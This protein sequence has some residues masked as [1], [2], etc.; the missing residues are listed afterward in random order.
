MHWTAFL[1]YHRYPAHA[2]VIADLPCAGC[3]YNLRSML[4]N[5]VCPE[6]GALVRDSLKVLSD[7]A[8]VSHSLRV[9]GQ[10]HFAFIFLFMGCIGTAAWTG[11]VS[12]AILSF[13]A[14]M[15]LP[16]AYDLRYRCRLD[17]L[18]I[19]G[20]R[21]R[22]LW[23]L[24]V[25]DAVFSIALC[26]AQYG[27]A[28]SAMGTS[29]LSVIL[30]LLRI[31][32]VMYFLCVLAAGWCGL[33]LTRMLDYTWA[34]WE[35]IAQRVLIAVGVLFL[36]GEFA[37][38]GAFISFRGLPVGLLCSVVMI[39]LGISIGAAGLIHLGNGAASETDT[40]DEIVD[41]DAFGEY[42]QPDDIPSLPP[43]AP[44]IPLATQ[45]KRSRS[46]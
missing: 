21:L 20:F 11:I 16:A 28:Q 18:P 12:F 14:V 26:V 1:A 43:Q 2:R 10:T 46:S 6:C 24:T 31:W 32:I 17:A 15:R 39:G 4:V 38:G 30:T 41:S 19:L 22:W 42:A 27:S 13:A 3:N 25:A 23:W 34:R 8:R 5:G 44:T 33:E 29:A 45:L 37:S 9:I 40:L 36:I 7:P 35:L